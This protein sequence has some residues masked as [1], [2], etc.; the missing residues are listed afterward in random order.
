MG[1]T[2]YTTYSRNLETDQYEVNPLC[3]STNRNHAFGYFKH[4]FYVYALKLHGL[5]ASKCI[6]FYENGWRLIKVSRPTQHSVRLECRTPEILNE[7]LCTEE[8]LH[9]GK[10]PLRETLFNRKVYQNSESKNSV[11]Y[12]STTHAS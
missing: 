2:T 9:E 7:F 5:D 11:T 1:N 3:S 8:K 4:D 6:Y 10:W 12:C